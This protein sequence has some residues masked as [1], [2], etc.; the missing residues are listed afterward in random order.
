MPVIVRATVPASEFALYH[1]LDTLPSIRLEVERVIKSGEHA[2]MPLLWVRGDD[3]DSVEEA[4]HEDETVRDVTLLAEFE[5][6]SLFRVEWVERIRLLVQ[7]ITNSEATI[8]DAHGRADRWQLRVLY[9]N[10]EMLSTSHEFCDEHG[11]TFDIESI[12]ELDAAPAGRYGLTEEQYQALVLAAERGYF[13]VPRAVSLETIAAEIELSHQAL[14]ERL[15][16]G[17]EALVE[18][19]LLVGDLPDKRWKN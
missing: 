11:L 8:L 15:R 12:R 5:Q 13:Q 10:H 7:M 9:P 16:R 18:D 14:S 4:F 3:V 1:V 6:E 2:V 17:T 19:T